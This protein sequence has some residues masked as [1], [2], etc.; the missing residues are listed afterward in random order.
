MK[1]TAMQGQEGKAR[2]LRLNRE[3]IRFLDDPA[4][5]GFAQGGGTFSQI[6]TGCITKTD[7]TSNGC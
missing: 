7:P 5:L 2:R 6:E 1:K 4:L 3:T